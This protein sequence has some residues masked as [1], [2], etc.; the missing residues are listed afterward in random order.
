[1]DRI[2][3]VN[4]INNING[5]NTTWNAAQ[6]YTNQLIPIM[7]VVGPQDVLV[8]DSLQGADLRNIA[9]VYYA[10][11]NPPARKSDIFP[12]QYRTPKYFPYTK[13]AVYSTR[14][15]SINDYFSGGR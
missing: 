7:T 2:D 14:Q 15:P 13:N 3:E 6:S 9:P 10:A 12:P 5:Q 1:M 8:Y 11:P 4:P